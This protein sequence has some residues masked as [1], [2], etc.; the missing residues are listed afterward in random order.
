MIGIAHLAENGVAGFQKLV[1]CI[2]NEYTGNIE[3]NSIC[4]LS[5]D[6]L[7]IYNVWS[8]GVALREGESLNGFPS[9]NSVH[10]Y[11]AR[12]M[13]DAAME[14]VVSFFREQL[15]NLFGEVGMQNKKL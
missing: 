11:E 3:K 5:G 4:Y 15:R 13:F 14:Y 10:I 7:M 8:T 9:R 2:E 1:V 12:M 6:K